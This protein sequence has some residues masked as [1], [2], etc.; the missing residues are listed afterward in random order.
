MDGSNVT[1]G[2]ID[3]NRFC[4][5]GKRAASAARIAIIFAMHSTRPGRL[6][7]G[8]TARAFL[9]RHWQKR[10]LLVRAAIAQFRGLLS[11]HEL[12]L[13]ACRDDAQ[14]RVVVRDGHAW[15]VHHGPFKPAFFRRLGGQRWTLLVQEVNHF[16]PAAQALLAR[17]RF[18]PDARL[19]DLMV[20]YAPPGGG[21]GPHVDSYDVFLLQGL[22]R[23]RWR[24]SAQR[25]LTLVQ[26]APLKL[27][28]RFRATREWVLAPGDL[29]YLPPRC[30]HDGVALDECMTYSIGFRAP[31]WE[32]LGSAFLDHLQDRLE[33][34]GLYAD[35]GLEPA[36]HP[37]RIGADLLRQAQAQ[38]ARIRWSRGD[39]LRF[40]GGWLTEPKPH[41]FF[42][43]PKAPVSRAVFLSR[44]RREGL[45][46]AAKSR[47]LYAGD[48]VFINGE[49]ERPRPT[50]LR[51]L[52]A[53]ADA[54]GIRLTG[55]EP[56]HLVELLR[57]WQRAGWL[58]F[59]AGCAQDEE[60]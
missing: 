6:L 26:G 29:L 20:S 24:V 5:G 32:E 28:A 13:L 14:A 3:S 21:V 12:M 41:V 59:A 53:L 2:A 17:F 55:R 49:C 44:A 27:L 33:L 45:A 23:R 9:A 54:G 42:S 46:L 15:R 47:M 8:M 43:A 52:Q 31:V 10:P 11:P 39:V 19:D 40:L 30:A 57:R 58:E 60:A 25:D 35:P 51:T 7:A 34:K 48:S 37:A 22:G 36:R 18:V 50:A 16:L 56:V 1:E 38:L 4:I